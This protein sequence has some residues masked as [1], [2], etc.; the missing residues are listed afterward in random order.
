MSSYL[1]GYA[2]DPISEW[3]KRAS[4]MQGLTALEDDPVESED[5]PEPEQEKGK[6]VDPGKLSYICNL[7]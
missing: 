3:K 2:A 6:P 1:P 5:E 4:K 7:L